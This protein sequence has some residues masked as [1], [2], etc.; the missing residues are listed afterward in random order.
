MNFANP[1]NLEIIYLLQKGPMNVKT[2]VEKT[3]FEQSTV[4]HNLK[5]L[6]ACN[7]ITFEQ[8]GRER[9]YSL[10]KETV[11]PLLK[12]VE[13]HIETHCDICRKNA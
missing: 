7:I 10:N 13:N 1:T 6:S 5:K 9:L 12:L 2:I 11:I 4:S 3:G 8:K